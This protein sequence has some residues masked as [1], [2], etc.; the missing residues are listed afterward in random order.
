[1]KNLKLIV[2]MLTFIFVCSISV[3]NTQA[4]NVTLTETGIIVEGRTLVPLRAIFEELE[5]SVNWEQSSQ[6][7]TA[8][9][10]NKKISL[11]IGSKNTTVNGKTVTID[12]PAQIIHGK[13]YVPL[14]FISESLG[15]SVKWDSK[16]QSASIS[17][18][19]KTI[20]VNAYPK[21]ELVITIDDTNNL[22]LLNGVALGS[23]KQEVRSVLG[24]PKR[25]EYD[26]YFDGYVDVYLL[27]N[28]STNQS[29]EVYAYF[30]NNNVELFMFDLS[31][32]IN[33][34]NWYKKLGK[35]FGEKYS[36]TYFYLEGTEQVLVFKSHGEG[37]I[38]V[39]DNNF[40]NTFGM[41]DKWV[42]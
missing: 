33:N 20:I 3:N 24:N 16:N 1:M 11:K 22:F 39:A 12:V 5:A 29:L 34:E 35:P 2:S 10:D 26:A 18:S 31:K 23:S 9:K 13:T 38:G 27:K 15:A 8:T 4:A 17:L 14:R 41:D 37:L 42:Y 30:Y 7:V 40:Y 21:N 36:D 25:V 6:T 32:T 19:T 28:S